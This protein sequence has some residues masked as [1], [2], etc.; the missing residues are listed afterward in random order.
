MNDFDV[1]DSYDATDPIKDRLAV[2]ERVV[3][4]LEADQGDGRFSA[5]RTD[6]LRLVA[7]L[8]RED[9]RKRDERRLRLIRTAL[10][11]L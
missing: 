9:L 4:A 11:E 3:D 5:R 10:Q 7:N 8:D 6:A 2:L 1:E